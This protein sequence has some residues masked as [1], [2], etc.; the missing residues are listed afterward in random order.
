MPRLGKWPQRWL[1]TAC[2]QW[3]SRAAGV[4]VRAAQL[5]VEHGVAHLIVLDAASGHP[6]GVISTLDVAA[7]YASGAHE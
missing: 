1:S 3:R 4:A 7:V 2:A 5:M 6:I